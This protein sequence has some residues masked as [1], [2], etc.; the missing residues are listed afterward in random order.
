MNSDE[1]EDVYPLTPLQEGM[2]YYS[3]HHADSSVYYQQFALTYR[4]RVDHESLRDA[5]QSVIDRHAALRTSVHWER[6]DQPVQVVH[7]SA[8]VDFPVLDWQHLSE[9]EWADA[10][11]ALREEDRVRGFDLLR[12]PLLGLRLIRLSDERWRLHVAIHH[13]VIDGW[14]FSV[15]AREVCEAYAALCAGGKPEFAEPVPFSDYV[16]LVQNREAQA[17]ESF[18]RRE[19]TGFTRPVDML[20]GRRPGLDDVGQ[21]QNHREFE[22]SAE[23][24][25][26]LLDACRRHRLTIAS[27]Q[28]AGWALLLSRYSGWDD[29]VFGSS[30]SGRAVDLPGVEDMVGLCVNT[31]PTRVHVHDDQPSLDFLRQVQAGAA[32]AREHAHLPLTR[33]QAWS[34]VPTGVELFDTIQ[35]VQNFERQ[36]AQ[37][38]AHALWD[39][40][41]GSQLIGHDHFVRTNYPLTLTSLPGERMVLRVS[42]APNWL[43]D[44]QAERL[45]ADL[46]A[47]MTGLVEDPDRPVGGIQ[48][49]DDEESVRLRGFSPLEDAG[50][51]PLH[52]QVEAW[53]ARTPEAPAAVHGEHTLTYGELDARA[54][55]LANY[56]LSR[57]LRT[58]GLV[59]VQVGDP[60][61]RLTAQLAVAKAGAVAFL[62]DPAAPGAAEHRSMTVGARLAVTDAASPT[63]LAKADV[64]LDTDADGIAVMDATSPEGDPQPAAVSHLVAPLQAGGAGLLVDHRAA[65]AAVAAWQAMLQV[66][67]G[68]RVLHFA[69]PGS[70]AAFTET[71]A[72]LAG[73]GCVCV[74]DR[75]EQAAD[76]FTATVARHEVTHAI[77]P[78][79]LLEA[80]P[81]PAQSALPSLRT[82]VGS[83]RR[84]EAR[85][86]EA[87]SAGRRLLVVN[88]A[89]ETAGLGTVTEHGE[90]TAPVVRPTP[91]TVARVLDTGGRPLPVGVA[92][93]LY[94]GGPQLVRGY[95]NRPGQTAEA[96]RMDP[97]E[98]VASERLFRTGY[99]ARWND[100]AGLEIVTGPDVVVTGDGALVD[101]EAIARV[102]RQD[103]E[104][105]QALVVRRGDT[106]ED[107]LTAY[108]VARP[109]TTQDAP[110]LADEQVNRWQELYDHT[111]R[112]TPET[113]ESEFN[114]IG[115]NS[116][117]DGSE[118]PAHEMREWLDNTLERIGALAPKKV[119]EIGCGT[120]MLLLPLCK[121]TE[122][123][124]GTDLSPAA[125]EYVAQQLDS[126]DYPP[127]KLLQR[128][129]DQLGDLP[130]R[131]FDTI[132]INS[133][134]QYF[135]SGEYLREVL[136]GLLRLLKPGGSLFV[137]DVRDLSLLRDM[138][139]SIA[140]SNGGTD[141]E[142]AALLAEAERVAAA[143][144]ELL[145]HP[146]FFQRLAADAPTPCTA[147]TQV[148][149][150][151]ADNEL[152]RFRY[153]AIITLTDESA[154]PPAPTV[155]KAEG[156]PAEVAGRIERLLAVEPA[157]LLVQDV[158]H[159]RVEA[160]RRFTGE[161]TAGGRLD[162]ELAAEVLRGADRDAA[163]S[164]E[165]LGSL[166]AR[167][168]YTVDL[169]HGRRPGTMDVLFTPEGTAVRVR[170]AVAEAVTHSGARLTPW[171]GC[172]N[173]PLAE[174]RTA[175][176]R[177]G[178]QAGLEATLPAWEVPSALMVLDS[179]PLT[180]FGELDS[181]ALPV[182]AE[183]TDGRLRAFVP[184]RDAT[185]LVVARVWEDVLGVQPVG[186]TDN[187]FALGGHSLVAMRIVSRLQRRF[188]R[189]LDLSVLL[190]CP[191][192]E[193]LAAVLRDGDQEQHGTRYVA[194]QPEG[195]GTP[196]F[197]VHPAGGNNLVYA[198]LVDE[199]GTDQPAY[200]LEEP[201][202]ARYGSIEEMSRSMVGT[203]RA[204]QPEGPYRLAG[205]SFGGMVAYELG[206]QLTV[207][208]DSEVEFVA[209][210]DTPIPRPL[211]PG[212]DE[213]ALWA[214]RTLRLCH[215]V[216][217]LF[218]CIIPLDEESL[219]GLS[220]S[221]Q[222]EALIQAA[223]GIGIF[224]G[225]VGTGIIEQIVKS[226]SPIAP[227]MRAYTPQP[228]DVPLWLF[229]SS[230]PMPEQARDPEFDREDANLGWDGE[231]ADRL[232]VIPVPG[233]HLTMLSLPHVD[234][235]AGQLRRMLDEI[236]GYER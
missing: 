212:A 41:E 206:R 79:A 140:L 221:R 40:I 66:A 132:V 38:L 85:G 157:A 185:E 144:G 181:A 6:L 10:D 19:L 214:R 59:P 80:L 198:E 216:E 205:L 178:L 3:A 97:L 28:Q 29:V 227:L 77:V 31:L 143:E 58:G 125:L 197:F 147:V 120:G 194:L 127:V 110:E 213:S 202:P 105:A 119:L 122:E 65:S 101:P 8:L 168:G 165:A 162:R 12:A 223:E 111:Y 91:H 35:T 27:V 232:T 139:L 90:G 1:I 164:P 149:Y 155:L 69:R 67:P 54:N 113:A 32:A 224:D 49:L 172:T 159:T 72:A 211:D 100:D 5:W 14:S 153:D 177:A 48:L 87:W 154:K 94:I 230:E 189:E 93:D 7:R 184:P 220:Q 222:L 142:P 163:L 57:G 156:A 11:H 17:A 23:S 124:W 137:G 187:F 89:E 136:S 217:N 9:Q 161:L 183:E 201:D 150:G 84:L 215:A 60:L 152:T 73:G 34:E 167:A 160:L 50:F 118:L 199:L 30:D 37:S 88:G 180:P 108:V 138:H 112:S 62:A 204:L 42:Y 193:R 121:R 102:L 56:L 109:D 83:G 4:G 228:L 70:V 74:P 174:R 75:D 192:V 235:L 82:V 166:G 203:I 18:W 20:R 26:Q 229:R 44:P 225:D 158:P 45:L 182:P 175:L 61:R 36:E 191:T 106:D 99:V 39:R 141:P 55:R 128:S 171:D 146:D 117:Y 95:H 134:I 63:G 130:A 16:S 196:L 231:L 151:L 129:A 96:F 47:L 219:L 135:P 25:Q 188:D 24:T 107:R 176:L 2:L 68:D 115:W 81:A 236:E 169:T 209:L 104:V 13:L 123:Y 51:T 208:H 233:N 131:N 195:D 64:H 190:G 76:R 234:T 43:S 186:A 98:Q 15:V 22:L 71:F 148:K 46:A 92:G 226:M 170:G 200:V 78:T 116:S 52:R 173:D 86:A 133:V 218:Q 53:A 126:G 145:C 114:I 210:L 33:V 207:E 179:V 21:E 103:Q